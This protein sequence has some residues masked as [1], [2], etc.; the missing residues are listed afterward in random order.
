VPTASDA[1]LP[2]GTP[3]PEPAQL[4]Y[5]SGLHAELRP[6]AYPADDWIRRRQYVPR[7]DLLAPDVASVMPLVE[8][9]ALMGLAAGW[10]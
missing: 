7:P 9:L 5:G 3:L 4:D 2:D 1:Q 8:A 10:R 6:G